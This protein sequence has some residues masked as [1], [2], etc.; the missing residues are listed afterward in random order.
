[1]TVRDIPK[2]QNAI[3]TKCNN[4]KIIVD[5]DSRESYCESC[6]YVIRTDIDEV[7]EH[8]TNKNFDQTYQEKQR[9]IAKRRN[10]RMCKGI[11]LQYKATKPAPPLGRYD[12]GQAQCQ[13]CQIYITKNGCT[14]KDGNT[15]TGDALPI[16]CKCCGLRVR[17][18]PRNKQAKDNFTKR[19]TSNK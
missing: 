3:C 15:A 5:K 16:A 14:D 1:M 18:R 7:K 11:C 9:E 8:S 19:L 12:T 2:K 13:T 17:T 6:G 10:P 4:G